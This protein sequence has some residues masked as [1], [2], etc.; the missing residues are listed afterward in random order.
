[1]D[2]SEKGLTLR[3]VTDGTS[4]TIIVVEADPKRAVEW[5][6]PEDWEM[7]ADNPHDGL[8]NVQPNVWLAAF[9]D[10]HVQAI[11]DTLDPNTLRAFFTR[12][13]GEVVNPNAPAAPIPAP[14]P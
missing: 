4:N 5:T 2:G 7:N 10:A 6:K 9:C 1:M 11:A 3:D 12:A 14:A 8:G 13:G